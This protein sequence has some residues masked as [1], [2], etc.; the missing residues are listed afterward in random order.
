MNLKNYSMNCIDE[1]LLQ[2]YIDGEC[3]E[4][5][6]VAV[7]QHLSGCLACT[8]KHAEMEKLSA[9]IKR[10]V[11][12]LTIDNIEIPAFRKPVARSLN[13][14]FKLFLYSLSAACIL[15]FALFFAN[16]KIE[17]P[18]NEISIV[19]ITPAEV[20]ANRTASDQDFVI[21]VYDSKGQ[22]SE[23]YIE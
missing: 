7:K 1:E 12:F 9:E 19:Q 2:K 4:N 17:S 5:E 15:L 22:G 23:Y 14:N 13:R 11:N 10:A 20:D 8:R 18:H 16:R 6:M 3:T 21:E